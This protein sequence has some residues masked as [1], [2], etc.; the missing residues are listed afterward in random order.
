MKRRNERVEKLLE[1]IISFLG[2]LGNFQYVY[3]TKITERIYWRYK[4][5]KYVLKGILAMKGKR[6]KNYSD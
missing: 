3:L 6:K 1:A 2:D 5:D 4:S